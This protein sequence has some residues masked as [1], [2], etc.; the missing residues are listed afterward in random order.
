M[1]KFISYLVGI[2]FLFSFLFLAGCRKYLD[3][4]PESGISG[5]QPFKNFTNFQ[6]FTERLYEG[7]PDFTNAY[8]INNWNWGDDI[9]TSSDMDY[10]IVNMFDNGNFWGWQHE[11]NGWNTSWMDKSTG[12]FGNI[13]GEG[14]RFDRDLWHDGWTSIRKV[15]IGL[16]NLDKL[17][18]TQEEK[19]L[20]KG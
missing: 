16:E 13:P 18:G 5:D 7:I 8:W 20:I 9:V 17:D 15:N 1:R 4:L 14:A 19:D 12:Q 3:K 10:Q 11:H 2:C 6:G